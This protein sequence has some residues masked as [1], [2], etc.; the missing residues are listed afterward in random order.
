[1][2]AFRNWLR[3]ANR[4]AVGLLNTKAKNDAATFKDNVGVVATLL[5]LFAPV[6][7][8]DPG[9]VEAVYRLCV[10]VNPS[11]VIEVDPVLG[12]CVLHNPLAATALF[13]SVS[14]DCELS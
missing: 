5:T 9:Q 8:P 11:D 1:M 2:V 3:T 4:S 13:K 14:G 6:C 7:F 12:D 10:S